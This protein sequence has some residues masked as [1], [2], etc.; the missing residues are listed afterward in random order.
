MFESVKMIKKILHV[1]RYAVSRVSRLAG[2]PLLQIISTKSRVT[3]LIYTRFHQEVYLCSIKYFCKK[4]IIY[5]RS[6]SVD[7]MSLNLTV[8]DSP[9]VTSKP[10]VQKRTKSPGGT[11]GTGPGAAKAASARNANRN[12]GIS[13]GGRRAKSKSP[14]PSFTSVLSRVKDWEIGAFTPK[15]ALVDNVEVD[16]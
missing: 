5:F 8:P 7:G 13:F 6:R 4:I 10:L 3:K 12:S 1:G 14:N 11:A 9:N 2:F 15:T 16:R